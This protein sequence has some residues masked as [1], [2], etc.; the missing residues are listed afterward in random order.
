MDH[1]ESP[2]ST[3]AD[4]QTTSLNSANGGWGSA[5]DNSSRDGSNDGSSESKNLEHLK[6]EGKSGKGVTMGRVAKGRDE[7]IIKK[8]REVKGNE[9]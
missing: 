7:I 1:I 5:R 8:R 2:K 9:V 3:R 4:S 6:L